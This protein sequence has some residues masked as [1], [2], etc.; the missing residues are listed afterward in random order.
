MNPA[1]P[2]TC[3]IGN[4]IDTCL[5]A[6]FWCVAHFGSCGDMDETGLIKGIWYARGDK[7]THSYTFFFNS[8]E[9]YTFF[10]LRWS[11]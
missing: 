8:A 6:Y 10:V 1:I 3:T 9:D 7:D 4:S 11:C 2:M 5:P